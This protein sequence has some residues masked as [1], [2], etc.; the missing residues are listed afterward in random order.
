LKWDEPHVTRHKQIC[1]LLHPKSWQSSRAG[2][3]KKPELE[4]D[5][6]KSLA[7]RNCQ[8][9]TDDDQEFYSRKLSKKPELENDGSKSFTTGNCKFTTD[10]DQEFYSRKLLIYNWRAS[11]FRVLLKHLPYSNSDRGVMRAQMAVIQH[12]L[13]RWETNKVT[14]PWIEDKRWNSIM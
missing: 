12:A 11:H 10:D 1:E 7:T 13:K 4:N 5:G 14:A 9:A 8:L 6:S 2:F 3:P